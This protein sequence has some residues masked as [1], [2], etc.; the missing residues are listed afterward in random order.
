[1]SLPITNFPLISNSFTSTFHLGCKNEIDF[2]L[3]QK[4]RNEKTHI[5]S[6]LQNKNRRKKTLIFY[7]NSN[8]A[9]FAQLKFSSKNTKLFLCDKYMTTIPSE[10]QIWFIKI[11]RK[12]IGCFLACFLSAFSFLFCFSLTVSLPR[13]HK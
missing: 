7:L 3:L 6:R 2:R 12:F 4:K 8:C 13:S 10:V 11:C 1:M 5:L 9:D